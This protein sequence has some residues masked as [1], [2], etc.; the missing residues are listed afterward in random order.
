[1]RGPTEEALATPAVQIFTRT[2]LTV[3][4]ARAG[5]SAFEGCDR[6]TNV[7]A[8]RPDWANPDRGLRTRSTRVTPPE[9]IGKIL[10]RSLSQAM[11]GEAPI[12]AGRGERR[13]RGG[14]IAPGSRC[15][16]CDVVSPLRAADDNGE[17]GAS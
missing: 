17:G 9:R 2:H 13:R 3:H 14:P 4:H 6:L 5:G 11:R 8:T 15:G 10:E 7:V 1:M 16:A 12:G